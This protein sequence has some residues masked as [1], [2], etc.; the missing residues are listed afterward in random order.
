MK[1]FHAREVSGEEKQRYWAIAEQFW[2]HFPEY[3]RRAAGRDIP[4][5]VLEPTAAPQ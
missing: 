3:R 2:P 1:D 4:I 5:M